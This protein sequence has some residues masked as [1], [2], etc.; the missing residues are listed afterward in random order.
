MNLSSIDLNLLWV[1]HVVLAERSVVAAAHKLNVT[2]PAV[3]NALSRLRDTLGDQLL[4]RQGRGL[5]PTP[6]A[7]ELQA[8]LSAAFGSIATALGSGD[9]FNPATCTRELTIALSDADQV[10]SLPLISS[11]FAR[12][13]PKAQLRVVTIDTLMANGGLAGPMVDATIGPPFEG[14]GLHRQTLFHEDSVLFV[15]KQ[16]PRVKTRL[17]ATQFNTER[18]VDIH[19]LLGKPG[20]GNRAFDDALRARQLVRNVAVT[21]PTFTA[22]AS[23]VSSTDFVSGMPRRMAELLSEAW[24]L[25]IVQ[26]PG[27]T[28]AF[29][30]CLHWHER[31]E[32]DPAAKEFRSLIFDALK[33]H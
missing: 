18:H 7:I 2:S 12:R 10:T 9:T 14:D 23:V 13:L 3:S 6:R 24:G 20:A 28:F 22:A 31:T 8:A 19:L 27:P 32:H 15:R 21:V 11:A 16:H 1:L 5:T 33:R 17:S 4:V 26:A 25:K 30:M 29:E